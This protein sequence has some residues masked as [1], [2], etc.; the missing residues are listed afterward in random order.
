MYYWVETVILS[1]LFADQR[2]KTLEIVWTVMQQA[3][4][5]KLYS[6]SSAVRA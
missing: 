3:E 4:P 2:F 1:C 6:G 5:C